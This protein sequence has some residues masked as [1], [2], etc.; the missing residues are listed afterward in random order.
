MLRIDAVG[1]IIFITSTCAILL[2]LIMGGQLFPWSSWRIIL[3]IVL[4]ALGWI[5][6]G[7]HQASSF[8]KEPTMPPRLFSNR[9]AV[10]GF[11]LVFISCMLLEW[12]VYFL[13]YYFQTLK[14]ASALRSAVQVLTFNIVLVPIA[15]ISGQLLYKFGQYKPL[16]WAGFGFVALSCGLFSTMDTNTPT[17]EW[18][19]WQIFASCGTGALVMSTLPAIQSSLPEEDV[20]TS[21]GVHAFLRSFGFAWGFTIPSL[22]FNNRVRANIGLVDDPEVAKIIASGEAYSQ[23]NSP[24]LASLTGTAK[25]QTLHLYAV[26]LRSIWYCALAFSLLGFLLVFVEKRI[27]LRESLQ[28]AFGLEEKPTTEAEVKA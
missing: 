16:H 9:T 14:G 6:F 23:A 7:F 28:T 8:C 1:N 4:G 11:A 20:A 17:A 25:E 18:V 15:A 5:L 12:I 24:F 2:G 19:F 10:T 26:S 13:P 21:T 3:P 27:E 22:V